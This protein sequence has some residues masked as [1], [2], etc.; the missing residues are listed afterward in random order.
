MVA[1]AAVDGRAK[2]ST[3]AGP[4][5]VLATTTT[6]HEAA[7]SSSAT[8][9]VVAFLRFR[10]SL[11]L[12]PACPAQRPKLLLLLLLPR[13]ASSPVVRRGEPRPRP[14][15]LPRP[16]PCPR[17]VLPPRLT[18]QVLMLWQLSPQRL[19]G[20]YVPV[21]RTTQKRSFVSTRV[22]YYPLLK[23]GGLVRAFERTKTPDL[24][25]PRRL[26]AP[27]VTYSRVS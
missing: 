22:V 19:H 14:R 10:L 1:V 21:R 25:C 2:G 17:P 16:R 9:G 15:L 7:A 11:S 18:G 3:S 27:P 13:V 12:A 20:M 5:Q 8:S 26:H 4:S 24:Q 6:A 23:R